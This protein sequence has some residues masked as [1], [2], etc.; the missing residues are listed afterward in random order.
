MNRGLI[1]LGTGLAGLT[2]A[3]V[4]LGFEDRLPEWDAGVR[5]G[6]PEITVQAE[7]DAEALATRGIEA[8]KEA[9]ASVSGPGAVL[10]PAGSYLLRHPIELQDGIVLRGRGA[11]E[12]TLI[13]D[14]APPEEDGSA[15]RP[16]YGAV[17]L[18]GIREAREIQIQGGYEKGSRTLRVEPGH[19][20]EAG[21]TILVYSEN[22]PGLMYTEERWD[23]SWALQ[24]LA[25]IVQVVHA[26]EAVV[27]IDF[28][29]RLDYK[30]ELLPRIQR[31]RPIE[32]AGVEDLTLIGAKGFDDT[33][34]GIEAAE[35]CWVRN[36]ETAYTGR[37]HIW[38]N[39]SR[40][41]TVTGNECRHAHDYGGGGN[42]YGIV[43]G[44]VATD[45]L[46]TDNLLHHLRHSLMTKR[47]SNGNVFA[48]NYSTERRRDPAGRPLL[49]DIS[50][51]GHYSYAN[52]FEGNVVDFVELADFWGP[53][54]PLTTLFRNR[55][56]KK[57][58]VRDHSHWT[59]V[60][61]N[62][63]LTGEIL[64]EDNCEHVLLLANREGD[65]P[66]CCP[67]PELPASLYFDE[68]PSF[69]GDLPWPSIGPGTEAERAI[70]IPAQLRWEESR[71]R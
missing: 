34:I 70:V 33:I 41:I 9:M 45:C 27:Q 3:T 48:F 6:I 56:A 52:L 13:F 28:A 23:V 47:G 7:V 51:H 59:N 24:S 8:V 22:D 58:E 30:T 66:S 29:L 12:T 20:L 5:G 42:G 65:T 32:R 19:G 46:V 69:W 71:R 63:L 57:L 15:V 2:L 14:I 18:S 62:D 38:I 40:F 60:I 1:L 54:G 44:N 4:S 36:V 43:A 39:F 64:V 16:A 11:G 10:L 49:C 25:Q 50:V 21:D 68:K 37:G 53:T 31:I 26:E 67:G 35:N 17:S 55:V 61:A